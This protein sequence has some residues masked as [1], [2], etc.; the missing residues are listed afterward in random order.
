[1][2]PVEDFGLLLFDLLF[3]GLAGGV[4]GAGGVLGGL[5]SLPLPLPL[6]LPLLALPPALT[7]WPAL[8]LS[9]LELLDCKGANLIYRIE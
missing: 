9:E 5:L 2:L 3:A 1:M 4:I 6:P 7:L 8:R